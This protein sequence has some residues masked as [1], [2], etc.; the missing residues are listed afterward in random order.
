MLQSEK[1]RPILSC[2]IIFCHK[3]CQSRILASR[4]GVRPAERSSAVRHLSLLFLL[5]VLS[6]LSLAQQ[7]GTTAEALLITT[8]SPSKGYLHQPYDFQLQA[9][10]GIPPLTW[11]IT[12]GV[13]PRGMKLF[14]DG[15]LGGTPNETGDF[16]IR[17]TVSDSGKPQSEKSRELILTILAPLLLEWIRYPQVIGHRIECAI[18]LS[19]QTGDNFDLTVIALA[20]NEIG[21]ATAVGYQHFVLQKNTIDMELSF[22]ENLPAGVYELNIDAVAEVPEANV[23]H[24]ARLV[25]GEKQQ[26]QQEP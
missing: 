21:R 13:L 26:I 24:R 14:P 12:A 22:G 3:I 4:K 5:V 25:T 8:T 16:R 18:K 10:G 15:H 9:Q 7:S 19:N 1:A 20:V 17:V 6:A 11:E 2:S 23:I